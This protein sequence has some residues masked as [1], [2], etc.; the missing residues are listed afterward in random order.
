M[1][2]M[3]SGGQLGWLQAIVRRRVRWNSLRL[4]C[5]LLL[6]FHHLLASGIKFQLPIPELPPL[7]GLDY[8][9]VSRDTGPNDIRYVIH[10]YDDHVRGN[11]SRPVVLAIP[12]AGVAQQVPF[13][14]PYATND[15]LIHEISE[16]LAPFQVSE[17]A[18]EADVVIVN[19]AIHVA[20]NIF[21]VSADEVPSAQV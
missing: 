2:A 8:L 20:V 12:N 1:S 5:F 15:M 9:A 16:R 6:L 17:D 11:I 21:L 13:T 3:L 10:I 19:P 4:L 7:R 14:D 18:L